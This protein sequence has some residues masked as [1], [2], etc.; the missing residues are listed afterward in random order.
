MLVLS[1]PFSNN[2]RKFKMAQIKFYNVK[3]KASVEI[4]EEQCWKVKY[5]RTKGG[6]PKENY[7]LRAKDDDGTT[8]TKFCKKEVFDSMNCPEQ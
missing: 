2:K 3:K 4:S 8:L 7:A 1:K 5:Q 6:G